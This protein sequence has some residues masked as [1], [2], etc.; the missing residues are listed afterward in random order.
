[1]RRLG[2]PTTAIGLAVP[3]A[4][5][6]FRCR[7]QALALTLLSGTLDP[8]TAQVIFPPGTASLTGRIYDSLTSGS[9]PRSRI[10]SEFSVPIYGRAMRCGRIDSLGY[11]V[12]D[13]LPEGPRTV[14]VSCAGRALLGGKLVGTVT[15]DLQEATTHE[16]DFR[17]DATACDPRPLR[18]LRGVFRGHYSAGFEHS[19]FVPCAS[20]LWPVPSDTAGMKEYERSV[21]VHPLPMRQLPGPSRWPPPGPPKFPGDDPWHYVEW[22]GVLEGPGHYGHLGVSGFRFVPDSVIAVRTPRQSDC[23]TRSRP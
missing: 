22:H 20:Q 8:A 1:M 18:V 14:S 13:S 23:R 10:C 12:F 19:E 3:W 21:W 2:A 7:F 11:Y 9:I 16:A 4:H 5:L 17:S 15:V 6:V